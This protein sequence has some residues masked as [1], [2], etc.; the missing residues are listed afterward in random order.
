V[1]NDLA[2]AIVTEGVRY[3]LDRATRTKVERPLTERADAYDA[4]L[5][6][7]H[8][9]RL[10]EEENY[11][12]A[13]QLL[14]QAV[15]I[16]PAFALAQTSLAST[17]TV[18]AVDGYERPNDAWPEADRCVRRALDVDA[19]LPEARSERS[20]FWFFFD[21]D[22]FWAESEWKRA[23]EAP[24]SPTLPDLLRAT[25]VKLWALGRTKEAL[26]MASRARSLD[27]V[28]PAF[29]IQEADLLLH[30]A[31]PSEAAAIYESVIA[32]N[33]EAVNAYFGLAD[34]YYDQRRF[35]EAIT[36]RRRGYHAL[37]QSMPESQRGDAEARYRAIDRAAA[38]A[39]LAA[40]SAQAAS[41]GYV[42]PL[43]CAR[44]RAR[45]GDRD[46]AF[47]DL[48]A[49]FEERSPGLVFL[50]VDRAWQTV[51]ADGRFA[52]AV[53]KAELP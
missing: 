35:E 15:T 50:R 26:V 32:T 29:A 33:P 23:T 40:M 4:Y 11:L 31:R 49:A 6:G 1:Q 36:I 38:E 13:R 20:S 24:A 47:N 12:N 7:L 39:E 42:S 17:F 16:D 2:R 48:D 22:W 34:A 5:R 37:G 8:A 43:E 18:M 27:R 52:S 10:G 19:D 21:R 51:R 9:F 28:S 14:R 25:A 45:L 53:A 44:A 3:P 30:D 46:G 41:N